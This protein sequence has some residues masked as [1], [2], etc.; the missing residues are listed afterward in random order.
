M[1][2][3]LLDTLKQ[4]YNLIWFCKKANIPF[5]VLA[6]QN[7]YYNRNDVLTH[8]AVKQKANQLHVGS[9]IRLIEFFSSR[10]NARSLEE[11]LKMSKEVNTV[12]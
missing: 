8:P 4:T 10:Q 3:V 1:N 5:R 9:D 6:F 7:G 12:R 2:S 11:S